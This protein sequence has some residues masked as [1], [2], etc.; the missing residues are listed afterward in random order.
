[1][2]HL[3]KCKCANIPTPM[4]GLALGIASLGWSWEN[5]APGSGLRE[6]MALSAAVMLLLLLI[7]FISQPLELW[8]EL[9]HPVIGS[10][11]PTF[12]MA[13]MVVSS[14]LLNS[15]PAIASGLWLFAVI[16]HLAFL[17]IFLVQR[18]PVFELHHLLPSWF[19]P[20]VGIA[21]ASL[22]CPSDTFYPLASALL[23]FAMISYLLMMPL[24]IYR[25]IFADTIP[26]SAKPTIAVLA[27]PS[28]LCLAAYLSLID[29]P[30]LLVATMLGGVAILMTCVI[31]IAFFH[32]LR[33]PFSPGYAAFTFPMVISATAL[34]KEAKLISQY[35]LP[36]ELLQALQQAAHIELTIAT[37]VVAYVAL[38]YCRHYTM[39]AKPSLA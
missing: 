34:F 32:L 12:A 27:A 28:S 39:S 13:L 36:P 7:K 26:D 10:V 17:G 31:Y 29:D 24:M 16:I 6:L 23:Y 8:R 9:A 1:M 25:L 37:V 2:Y 30:S 38:R 21:V 5:V 3:I 18:L 11:I 4:A 35:Q 15:H 20:P 33:L 22:T 14:A 19:V